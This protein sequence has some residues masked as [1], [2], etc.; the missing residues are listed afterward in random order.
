MGMSW[1]ANFDLVSFAT[2]KQPMKEEIASKNLP[3]VP[4]ETTPRHSQ[5]QSTTK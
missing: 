4:F 3:I 5:V 1:G 2:L